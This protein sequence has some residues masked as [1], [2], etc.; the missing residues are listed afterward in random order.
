M[1]IEDSFNSLKFSTFWKTDR[2]GAEGTKS[3]TKSSTGSTVTETIE[4]PLGYKCLPTIAWSIDGS[5]FYPANAQVT[6]SNPYTVNVSV[7]DSIVTFYIYNNSGSNQ[8]FTIKYALDT[9]Q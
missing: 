2:I 5:N 7:S 6:P 9:Y 4:N 8:T 1:A 3:Y